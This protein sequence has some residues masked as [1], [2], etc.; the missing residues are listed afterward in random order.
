MNWYPILIGNI[1]M[2]RSNRGYRPYLTVSFFEKTSENFNHKWKHFRKET[3]PI[4]GYILLHS[5]VPEKEN[6]FK[7]SLFLCKLIKYLFNKT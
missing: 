1:N 3:L 7:Y 2:I 5:L 6:M 4:L